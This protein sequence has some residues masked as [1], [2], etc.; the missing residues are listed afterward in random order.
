MRLVISFLFSLVLVIRLDILVM[1]KGFEIWDWGELNQHVYCNL[2]S[3]VP[4]LFLHMKKVEWWSGKEAIHLTYN[5]KFIIHA[6]S[7]RTRVM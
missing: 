4:W 7:K 6:W 5:N 2:N 1:M 3:L